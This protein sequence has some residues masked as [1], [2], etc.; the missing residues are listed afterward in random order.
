[1]AATPLPERIVNTVVGNAEHS[2][3][4]RQ[5]MIL[6]RDADISHSAPKSS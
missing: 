2:P 5:S 3:P 1:V 4:C 6:L